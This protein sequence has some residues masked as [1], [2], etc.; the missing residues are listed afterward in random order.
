MLPEIIIWAASIITI[1]G[2][3]ETDQ[4]L[5][6]GT[7]TINCVFEQDSSTDNTC[8][9]N[10]T[11]LHF[12][13]SNNA[14]GQHCYF[15]NIDKIN[16]G[17]Y[18]GFNLARATLVASILLFILNFL[19]MIGS[20]IWHDAWYG[21]KKW[22]DTEVEVRL[23][24]LLDM[25]NKGLLPIQFT[26]VDHDFYS[27]KKGDGL[28]YDKNQQY[29]KWKEEK[30]ELDRKKRQNKVQPISDNG[31]STHVGLEDPKPLTLLEYLLMLTELGISS[32]LFQRALF[33]SAKV[34]FAMLALTFFLAVQ[35]MLFP[36][37]LKEE[38]FLAGCPQ[39][40]D[41]F[42]QVSSK[43]ERVIKTQNSTIVSLVVCFISLAW[44]LTG[45][46]EERADRFKSF[47]EHTI[48]KL[49]RDSAAAPEE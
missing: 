13:M 17:W 7:N 9:Y 24:K 2:Y 19:K 29:I 38:P 41:K 49:Q 27:K 32:S 14:T 5:Y 11:L 12:E 20:V 25:T 10:T 45:S 42:V 47:K 6:D 21:H 15:S 26:F 37:S 3:R 16:S 8:M 18:Y 34:M 22:T 43:L 28:L 33:S 1:I 48:E 40:L 30:D 44:T 35:Y 46:L 4:L 36:C 23:L 39:V 31:R